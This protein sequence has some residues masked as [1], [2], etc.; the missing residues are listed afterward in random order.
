MAH[1]AGQ[2]RPGLG[3]GALAH[4]MAGLAFLEHFLALGDKLGVKRRNGGRGFLLRLFLFDRDL[5]PGSLLRG[6][7]RHGSLSRL[8][9]IGGLRACL[10]GRHIQHRRAHGYLHAILAI[11]HAGFSVSDKHGV[12]PVIGEEI[13]HIRHHHFREIL[14]AQLEIIINDF[15]HIEK[16]GGDGVD[17]IRRE[18]LRLAKGHGAV[19]V[20]INGRGVGPVGADCLDRIFAGQR[21]MTAHQHRP[22]PG[23]LAEIAMTDGAFLDK[24]L[25]PGEHVARPF[26]QAL[27]VRTHINVP[28]GDFLLRRLAA[29]RE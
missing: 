3:F 17:F 5:L 10:L 22:A 13:L 21:A 7:R 15:I 12:G 27:P 16:I 8:R 19:D 2:D 1:N 9:S 26:G 6:H 24:D 25:L 23:A 14:M 28:G 11:L 4:L 20:I 18:R 29:Q